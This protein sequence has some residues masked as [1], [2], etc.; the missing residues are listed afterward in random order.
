MLLC[1]RLRLQSIALS[2]ART[3]AVFAVCRRFLLLPIVHDVV[4]N[5]FWCSFPAKVSRRTEEVHGAAYSCDIAHHRVH[6]VLCF[7]QV[8][9]FFTSMIQ[10]MYCG[11]CSTYGYISILLTIESPIPVKQYASCAAHSRSDRTRLCVSLCFVFLCV[12]S[13]ARC[14]LNIL[15]GTRSTTRNGSGSILTITSYAW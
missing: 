6:L 8:S 11:E 15:C 14:S 3:R 5:A 2:S 10:G 7:C 1:L 9:S 12:L 4:L 13:T